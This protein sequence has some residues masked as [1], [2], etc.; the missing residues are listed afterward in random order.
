[1]GRI[2]AVTNQ[3][4]GVGKTTSSINVSAALAH[5]GHKILLVDIDSQANA[6]TGVGVYKGDVKR[7]IFDLLVDNLDPKSVIMATSEKNL[8]LIPSSQELSGIDSL[9]MTEKKREFKLRE[10]LE[11]IKDD[12]DYIIVDCPPS[13]GLLTINA[14]TAADSTLIPVQC[15]YYALEGLTQLLNTIRIVQKRLNPN[16]AIEGVL[17]T[18][19]DR[20]TNLGLDVINEVKLYFKEKVFNTIIPRMVRLSEAPS[21]GKSIIDYDLTSKASEYYI[22]LAKEVVK[23]SGN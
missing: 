17:L 18:M 2:I 4:G 16:L 5:L 15:E 10:K 3:K 12:Y 1:M 21:F 11:L 6:S 13:L 9:I 14:L 23:N 7:T 20:R 22:D 19:L 8:Y